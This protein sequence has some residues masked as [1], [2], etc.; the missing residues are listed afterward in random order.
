MSGPLVSIVI[1]T[2]NSEKVLP[3]CLESIRKQTY[4][5]IEVIIVDSYSSDRTLEIAKTFGAKIITTHGGLLWARYLGHLHA[6]GEIEVLVD[7]DQILGYDTIERGVNMISQG[8]DAVIL[9]EKS[10]KPKTPS[11]W[12]FYFVR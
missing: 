2:Y 9:E 10:Y 4:K 1:P 12:L 3:L 8:C 7:S 6:K 11:Q 5:N